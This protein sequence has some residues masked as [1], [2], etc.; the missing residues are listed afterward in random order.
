[1]CSHN[2]CIIFLVLRG[3]LVNKVSAVLFHCHLKQ[4]STANTK[5]A[6]TLVFSSKNKKPFLKGLFNNAAEK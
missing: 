5:N 4:Q 3:L 1:M 2:L 6:K